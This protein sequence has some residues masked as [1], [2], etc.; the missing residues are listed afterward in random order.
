MTD[1]AASD[2]RA[3]AVAPVDGRRQRAGFRLMTAAHT[4]AMPGGT[5]P[6]PPYAFRAPRTG[7]GAFTT[8]PV[9]AVRALGAVTA[10]MAS[11]S[12][13]SASLAGRAATI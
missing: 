6:I 3:H 11:A 5:P 9:F 13:A 10:S 7:S 12:M 1:D 2:V 4:L 8:T